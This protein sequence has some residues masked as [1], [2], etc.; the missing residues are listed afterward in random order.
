MLLY[1]VLMAVALMAI[2][3][4]VALIGGSDEETPPGRSPSQEQTAPPV[5]GPRA[6]VEIIKCSVEPN[7]RWPNAELRIT[8][9]SS[10]TSDYWVEVE[11]VDADGV[12]IAEGVAGTSNLAPDQVANESAS[13]FREA[14]GKVV[15]RITDVTRH[16]S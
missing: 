3:V 12:R 9:H 14:S 13:G 10:K 16:A 1:V 2:L 4:A 8:N 11:F 6:D 15:C 7:T 5:S